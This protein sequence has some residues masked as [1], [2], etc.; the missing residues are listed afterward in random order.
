M[1]EQQILK[2]CGQV[3]WWTS[4][5]VPCPSW[6]Y[7]A[8]NISKKSQETALAKSLKTEKAKSCLKWVW[9]AIEISHCPFRVERVQCSQLATT[10]LVGLHKWRSVEPTRG[11]HPDHRDCATHRRIGAFFH[12]TAFQGQPW[13]DCHS[14]EDHFPLPLSFWIKP[15]VYQA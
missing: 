15:T 7:A 2:T 6:S 5:V 11:P 12:I 3:K 14:T 1:G 9:I 4:S 8:S 10:R 13:L